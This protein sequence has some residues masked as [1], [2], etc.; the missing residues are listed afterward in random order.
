VFS[1]CEILQC[2]LCTVSSK[3]RASNVVKF[4]FALRPKPLKPTLRLPTT[5]NWATWPANSELILS[6]PIHHPILC[7]TPL[8]AP[9]SG[10]FPNFTNIDNI[11]FD[12]TRVGQ[13]PVLC[14][15]VCRLHALLW[16]QK[17]I[18]ARC[19]PK[20]NE[21][22]WEACVLY[23]HLWDNDLEKDATNAIQLFALCIAMTKAE[24]QWRAKE[25]K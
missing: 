19:V 16:E 23:R 13:L 12:W 6:R 5:K 22:I 8:K 17:N 14:C 18:N 3:L 7:H 1:V 4:A 15:A 25:T 11:Y 24:I 2:C 9:Y 20:P 21:R 10:C